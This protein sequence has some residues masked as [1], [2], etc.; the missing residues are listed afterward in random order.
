MGKIRAMSDVVWISHADREI[1]AGC[2]GEINAGNFIVLNRELGIRCMKCVGLADLV[3]LESGDAALTRRAAKLSTRH[4]VVVRFNRRRNRNERQGTL[5]EEAALREAEKQCRDDAAA[6]EA[7]A[8]KRRERDAVRD[9][10]YID[11]FRARILELFPACPPDEASEIAKHACEKYS[12]RVGRTS[13][14]K[15]LE[16]KAIELAVQAHVRHVHTDYDHRIDE[17]GRQ[18]AREWVAGRIHEVLRSWRS[19]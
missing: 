13:W 14:A 15:E 17:V 19:S 9:F 16:P 5:V 8:V 18:D 10:E 3:Y 2:K 6:R 4:A 7:K 12:G 1:C 11:R